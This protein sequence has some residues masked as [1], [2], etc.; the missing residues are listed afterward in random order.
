MFKKHSIQTNFN[1]NFV[2]VEFQNNFVQSVEFLT[3]KIYFKGKWQQ[4]ILLS[5]LKENLK[6]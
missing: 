6:Q 1:N 4:K 3:P 2:Q 5:H